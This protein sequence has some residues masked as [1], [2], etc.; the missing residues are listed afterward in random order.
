M[1]A[2]P[3]RSALAGATLVVAFGSACGDPFALPPARIEN[4]VDTVSLW[5]FTGTELSLPSAYSI[6]GFPQAVR[7]DR[8]DGFDFAFDL[9]E[10]GRALLFPTGAVDL[11]RRSGI[12]LTGVPF[13]S[14]RAPPAGVYQDTVPVA[15]DVDT[16]AVIRSRALQCNPLL[17][18][19]SYYA[20][21]RVLA[22][23]LTERRLDFEILANSNCGYRSLEPGVPRR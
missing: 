20:K 18:A 19:L 3:L 11:G 5:A 9:D 22:V 4:V 10:A 17:P 23:D 14:I 21:L 7:T 1:R 12:L 8:T 2:P 6:L 13:D 15:V 16:V